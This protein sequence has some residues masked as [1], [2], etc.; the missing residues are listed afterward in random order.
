MKKPD[1]FSYLDFR[2]YLKDSFEAIKA[3]NP[4]ASYRSFA[5]EAG[6]TSPNLLQLIISGKRDLSSSTLPGTVRALGLNKQEADFFADMVAF[7]QS[8]G[9]EE[10]NFH[11]QRMLRSRRYAAVKAVEKIQFQY[12]DQWYHPVV[13]ELVAHPRFDGRADWI[14]SRILPKVTA[15]QV[16]RSLELLSALGLIRRE[17]TDGRWRQV[18][19]TIST[20]AEVADLAVANYHRSMLRLAA[21][22]IQAYPPETRDLRSVTLGIPRKAVPGLKR[23]LEE[24][25]K[26]LVALGNAE[27]AVEDVVVVNLQMFPA[28][29]PDAHEED[30][31]RTRDYPAP[32]P[33]GPDGV[34]RD[35]RDG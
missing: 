1:L 13:R 5:K 17:A 32:A 27:E 7:C 26:D 34:G 35:E 31:A 12:F 21:D 14:A 23:R 2:K 3:S 18:D 20:P 30:P 15:A 10:K 28:T 16:E 22:S 33:G 24:F 25:W 4:K 19:A 29:Q 9:F 8:A 6:Y 11:Y